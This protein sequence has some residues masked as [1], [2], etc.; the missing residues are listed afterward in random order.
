MQ[1]R[2]EQMAG[3]LRILSSKSGTVIEAQV[4]LSH[5]LQPEP[6]TRARNG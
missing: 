4:P 1:E 2:M 6:D 5:M 3:T